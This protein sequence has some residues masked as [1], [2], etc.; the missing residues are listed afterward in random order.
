[1]LF[2]PS[3]FGIVMFEIQK[4]KWAIICVA[5][6]PAFAIITYQALR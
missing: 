6:A 2:Y 3:A 1:M 4:A 5:I